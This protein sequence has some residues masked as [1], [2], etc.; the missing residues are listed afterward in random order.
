MFSSMKATAA[1]F[2]STQRAQWTSQHQSHLLQQSARLSASNDLQERLLHAGRDFDLKLFEEV[3]GACG[4][5]RDSVYGRERMARFW[6]CLLRD[7]TGQA[8][9]A[10]DLLQDL[11]GMQ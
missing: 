4:R 9:K 6:E 2:W 8:E 3:V 10:D 1:Q 11:L 5:G 7:G